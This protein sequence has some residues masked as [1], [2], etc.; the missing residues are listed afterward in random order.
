MHTADNKRIWLLLS[1]L[2]PNP[3]YAELLSHRYYYLPRLIKYIE[4]AAKKNK[5]DI[6][7]EK[8]R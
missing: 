1:A 6:K 7:K 5:I 8:V 4:K 2:S 3:A